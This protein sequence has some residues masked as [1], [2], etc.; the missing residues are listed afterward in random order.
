MRIYQETIQIPSDERYGLTAQIR[1]AAASIPANIAEGC[2]REGEKELARFMAI[3]SGSANEVEYHL[4]L[5]RDHA[6]INIDIH[7][8]HDQLISEVKKMLNTNY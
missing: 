8:R 7:E 3:A 4:F 1:R 5:A 2:G 6:Y